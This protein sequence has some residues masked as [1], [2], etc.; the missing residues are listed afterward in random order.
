MC[1]SS[2]GVWPWGREA[3]VPCSLPIAHRPSPL[4]GVSLGCSLL[5]DL[6]RTADLPHWLVSPFPLRRPKGKSAQ[7][8]PGC[9]L[10]QPRAGRPMPAALSS[11]LPCV[12]IPSDK[13]RSSQKA[14]CLPFQRQILWVEVS[15]PI[16]AKL[17]ISTHP[18]Q[19]GKKKQA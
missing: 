4:V 17:T 19:R 13:L 16:N 3:E 18:L 1:S 11:V 7:Q 9:L 14:L 5:W 12:N 2:K 8:S 10:R 15:H 6:A